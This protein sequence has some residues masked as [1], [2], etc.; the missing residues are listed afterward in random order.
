MSLRN[1]RGGFYAARD[2]GVVVGARLHSWAM[3]PRLLVLL[4]LCLLPLHAR[5]QENSDPS[6][7]EDANVGAN[8]QKTLAELMNDLRSST[9]SARLYAG[10]S[11]KGQLKRALAKEAHGKP[12]SIARD[13]ALSKLV[14]LEA[15][16]P[17]TCEAAFQFPNAVAPC[18]DML[19][20][21]EVTASLPQLQA[22]LA[23][24]TRPKVREHLEAAITQLGG[25]P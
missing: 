15:R 1:P 19:A 6:Q 2:P 20:M 8:A 21:L 22:A 23:A 7:D 5:A 24:E 3:S 12:G 17:E 25:A 4:L 10:R 13:E 9:P 18:A 16:L 11:L 14:E